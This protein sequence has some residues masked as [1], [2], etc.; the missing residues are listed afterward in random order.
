PRDL[1]A[2]IA[3]WFY[4][5]TWQPQPLTQQVA[6]HS[7]NKSRWLM[8]A[9][10][11]S[12]SAQL[13]RTME[14][15][16][17][18]VIAVYAAPAFKKISPRHFE[19]S[20][21]RV[22]DYQ[23]L[24]AE[25]LSEANTAIA[26]IAHLWS[27]DS[28]TRSVAQAALP[29]DDYTALSA[30]A[31]EFGCLSVMSLVQALGAHELKH[32]PRL[33]LITSDVHVFNSLREGEFENSFFEM[34][35]DNSPF[36]R[37]RANSPLEEAQG[38][39]IA[40]SINFIDAIASQH[41][42]Q[43]IPLKGGLFQSPLWGL[44]AVL[45]NEHPEFHCTRLDLS[46]APQEIEINALAAELRANAD[47]DQI[48]LR[49]ERRFAARLRPSPLASEENV[50]PKAEAKIR[51]RA[52]QNYV[53]VIDKPGVLDH[54][55]LRARSRRNPD[56]YEIEIQVKAAGLN[57]LD[58]MKAMGVYPGLDPNLP[59]ALGGECAGVVTAVG[60]SV[61]EFKV[62]DE[63]VALTPS[64]NHVSVFSA[65]VTVPSRLASR[66]PPNLSFAEAATMPA[67]FLTAQYAL[68]YLGRMS[69]GER[70]LIHSASGGVGL[71][72]VQLAQRAGC[73][74][75]ATAGTEEKRD[76]L[77]ALGVARVFNSRSLDFAEEILQRSRM[78]DG[79]LRM[80][81]GGSRIEKDDP[82]STIH[83]QQ[84]TILDPQ[85]STLD[86]RFSKPGVDLVLNSL[87]GEAIPKSL[88][89][90]RPYGRFL[91]IGKRDIYQNT[92]IGLE[93]FKNNLSY[94]AIDLAAVIAERQQFMGTILRSVLALCEQ[95]E[96]RPLPLQSFAI[97]EAAS[98]FRA[99]AQGKHIGKIV[100]TFEEEHVL[101]APSQRDLFNADATYLITGGMGGIGLRVANWMVEQGARHLV[102]V[103]RNAPGPAAQTAIAAM[104][105][106]GAQI[107]I[108]Q[109]DVSVATQLLALLADVRQ[110]M[111]P[112]KGVIHAAGVLDD[113]ILQQ[114][115]AARFANAMRPKVAGAWLLHELTQADAL[116]Y[117]VLFSSAAAILGTTGQ[118]NY[119]AG[120]AFMD[121][122]A[123]HRRALGL[124]ALSI[125][126][127]PW[128]EVGLA[129][130]QGNR[131]NRLESLGLSSIAPDEG[132]AAF[133]SLLRSP[134]TQSV[135]MPLDYA[136]WQEHYPAAQTASLF[137]QL[138][139]DLRANES[140][141]TENNIAQARLRPLNLR[142]QL[143]ALEAGRKRRALLETHL[144]EQVANVLKLKPSLVTR[145]KPFRSL[146]LDSLM[147]L[148]L[149]NRLE[150]SLG[151]TLPATTFFNYPNIT[152]LMPHLAAKM[153]MPLEAEAVKPKAGEVKS[154][155]R[156]SDLANL[157]K[158]EAQV[159][160]RANEE[161]D[162]DKILAE[163][164]QLSEEEARKILGK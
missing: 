72:A 89:V 95:G 37:E 15:L 97:S 131:G 91:E 55:T 34:G 31:H 9:D 3:D 71:A 164:E 35:L 99:M 78:E 21:A 121:A 106:A 85:S 42:I 90:L 40:A 136:Q 103:G 151:L 98:A 130:A 53:L 112:L 4:E 110:Q 65:F 70:V 45:A 46:A 5:V 56:K 22:E 104:Q 125:N 124:P 140:T 108:A 36:K 26:G 73:E 41:E 47:E 139:S 88:A 146:G 80:E 161:Y 13:I 145:N 19:I 30:S 50:E 86:P 135:V 69:A 111:P 134:Q 132:I 52:E 39:V 137:K 144:Q 105:N 12:V 138:Q 75:F 94:F 118:S 8:F 25:I 24:L 123:H 126:W 149:R 43:N 66:K 84:S 143:F 133:A 29:A 162:I 81:D 114:M 17:E 57:F 155:L 7:G 92:R 2:K 1:N 62:G 109:A 160:L 122:L 11:S 148:E 153:E 48:A 150:A 23:R 68:E 64:F 127:G 93:P 128:A 159:R 120:N 6:K 27:L 119:A 38:D 20:P 61:D 76:Y 113:G 51:A 67:A 101:I 147:A 28:S 60:A 163:I 115:N 83:D 54:L 152:A 59:I 100:L 49:G 107:M 32:H 10:Q 18:E 154:D 117:F 158:V 129:A 157:E 96:L 156:K 33:W 63:V 82:R 141:H 77:R 79:G 14:E 44:G 102:L 74:I 58:V 87:A 142:A 116:D 16:G